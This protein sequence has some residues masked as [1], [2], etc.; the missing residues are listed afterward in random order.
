M[1]WNG[2]DVWLSRLAGD[3]LGVERACQAR[4]DFA[5]HVEEIGERLVEPTYQPGFRLVPAVLPASPSGMPS[6]ASRWIRRV[7]WWRPGANCSTA[8]AA[9][10]APAQR[11]CR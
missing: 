6:R 8:A 7:C 10:G 3:E 2:A 11:P 9:S 4:D 1:Q 5:L